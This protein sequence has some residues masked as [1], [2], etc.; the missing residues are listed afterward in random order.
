MNAV[1]I[2]RSKYGSTARYAHMLAQKLDCPCREIRGLKV[3][4]LAGFDTVL[5]GGGLYAGRVS[6][7]PFLKKFCAKM[8]QKRVLVFGVG[9]SPL[10]AEEVEKIRRANFQGP[11]EHIPF[12]Y[13]RG[14]C[15]EQVMTWK[16]RT[17]CRLLRR[18]LEKNPPAS[19]PPWAEALQEA[20]EKRCDWVDESFL[21]PLLNQL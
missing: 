9:A 21:Q 19:M 15:D 1:V 12:V 6:C 10:D 3:E 20:D 7:V 16:D 17:L 8:P 18:S 4:K 14:A 11:L 5:A 13:C 2:Y